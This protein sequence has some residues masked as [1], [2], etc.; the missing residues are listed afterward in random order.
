MISANRTLYALFGNPVSHS[1]SPLMHNTALGY[2]DI[3]GIYVAF[4][5]KN[6]KNAVDKIRSLDIAGASITIPHKMDIMKYLDRLGD[7]AQAIGAVNTIINENGILFGSNT[8]AGGAIKALSEQTE[9]KGKKIA[10][11]GAGGAARAVVYAM[12]LKG[13]KVTVINRTIPNGEKI[14]TDFNTDFRPLSENGKYDYEIIINTT[15][16][17]MSSAHQGSPIKKEHLEKGMT[18]MDIVY[19]PL[20]TKLLA[21]AE[22]KGCNIV[23]G[24]AMFVYQGALQLELFT[25]RKAPVDIMRKSVEAALRTL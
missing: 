14:A 11:F 7:T 25:G 24:L 20:K 17:G 21:E 12:N 6:A 5:I 9:I 13:G 4:R 19:H 3:N 15:S 22:E 18:V 10:I 2:L 1:M 8:D 23:D 16:I